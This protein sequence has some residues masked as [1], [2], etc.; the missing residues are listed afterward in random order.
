[1]AKISMS[2]QYAIPKTA[3]YLPTSNQFTAAFNVPTPGLYDFNAAGNLNR[4]VLA[5]NTNAIY[6]INRITVGGTISQETY[7]A[8]LVTL[9][10]MQLR[11]FK[12]SQRIYPL[13]IPLNQFID[14]QEAV[15]WF[16]T[17]KDGES[18]TMSIPTGQLAQDAELVG[19]PDIKLNI[20][21]S[22]FEITDN[23]FIQDFKNNNSLTRIGQRTALKADNLFYVG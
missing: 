11:F 9:P 19:V 1:M 16:W 22:I 13:S 10:F 3:T 20:S 2:L 6:L 15:A 12:E 5:M 18:I 23:G 21:L 14:G 17:D 8:N 7:L 4:P